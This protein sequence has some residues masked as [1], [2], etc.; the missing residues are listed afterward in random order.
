MSRT[1]I[2][3]RKSAVAF[4]CPHTQA[5]EDARIVADT[6]G[7]LAEGH[8]ARIVVAVLDAPMGADGIGAS[9][10]RDGSGG[11]IIGGGGGHVPQAGFAVALV[12]G[13]CHHDDG[14]DEVLPFGSGDR[15]GSVE[16]GNGAGFAAIVAFV[17][18]R[19]GAG[20]FG[21]GRGGFHFFAQ[22]GLVVFQLNDE[23]GFGLDSG[24]KS[25][26]DSAWR[27]A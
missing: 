12:C 2:G 19:L 7:V 1:T 21:R 27:R 6:G 16:D 15:R 18:A 3:T 4:L 17:L 10:C 8:I 14:G 25:F 20:W 23:M 22:S 24:L 13:P 26:F 9:A 11:Q 5:G